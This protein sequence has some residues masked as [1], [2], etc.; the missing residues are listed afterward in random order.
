LERQ[1]SAEIELGDAKLAVALKC[2]GVK[3]PVYTE[4]DVEFH[5]SPT[6]FVELLNSIRSYRSM[7]RLVSVVADFG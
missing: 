3:R 4:L 1:G 7:V 6:G 2:V 5:E